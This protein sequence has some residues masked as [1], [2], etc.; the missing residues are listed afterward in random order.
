MWAQN[1]RAVDV[2]FFPAV[3]AF[4]R[5]LRDLLHLRQCLGEKTMGTSD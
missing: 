1:G 3:H 5:D 2:A 4:C